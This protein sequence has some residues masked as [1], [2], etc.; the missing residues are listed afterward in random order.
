MRNIKNIN[1]MPDKIEKFISIEKKKKFFMQ[2][3]S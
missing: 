2:K 1:N 3:T